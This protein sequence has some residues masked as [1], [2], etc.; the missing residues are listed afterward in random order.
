MALILN[1]DTAIDKASICLGSD[2]KLLAF[3]ENDNRNQQ[4]AWLHEAIKKM[5]QSQKLL[6]A[7]LDA[8]AV[9]NGPGS[10]TGLRIGLATAKGLCYSLNKP[11]ICLNTLEI[12]AVAASSNEADF[13]CPMIDARRMEVYT[14][15]YNQALHIV[16]P[17]TAMILD[18]ESFSDLLTESRILFAGNGSI[19]FKELIK[20]NPHAKFSTVK[21]NAS[22]ML[23]MSEKEYIK[24]SFAAIAYIEPNYV[25]DVYII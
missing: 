22:N 3:A 12:I 17:Q 20:N 23:Y 25:K 16:I 7:E 9:S 18:T 15:L 1:I 13:I 24:K 6:L 14:V 2:G 19:K 10:Y 8:I 21:A 4:A 5:L 11:L